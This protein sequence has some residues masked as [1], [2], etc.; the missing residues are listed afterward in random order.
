MGNTFFLSGRQK[1][2]YVMSTSFDFILL[3]LFLVIAAAYQNFLDFHEDRQ[4]SFSEDERVYL[5]AEKFAGG[6]SFDDVRRLL[7]DCYDI[8]E[9]NAEEILKWA[10][11]HRKDRDGGYRFFLRSVNRSLGE[12]VYHERHR[13]N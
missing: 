5:A 9:E 6:A 7:E 8:D 2:V 12:N 3:I 4:W 11:S 10:S 13:M 1:G